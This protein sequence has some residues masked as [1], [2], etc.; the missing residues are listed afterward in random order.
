MAKYIYGIIDSENKKTF[1][2][3][4]VGNGE[5]YIVQFGELGA[6]VSD[7]F[8]NCR[9]GIEEAKTHEKVLCKIMDPYSLI[10]MGFGLVAKNEKEIKNIQ[11]R[12]KMQFKKTLEKVDN[13][14]QIN[15]KI[16]WN[17][18]ILA[19]VLNENKHIKELV[20]A[21]KKNNDQT[22]RV[23][24]GKKV[25]EALDEK[26]LEYITDIEHSLGT[27]LLDS[28]E[29]KNE[30]QDTLT[31]MS[32]LIDKN[33]EQDFNERLNKL[34]EKYA[35]RLEFL[36]VGHLPAYNFTKIC[37]KKM[38]FDELDDA[39]KT[40]GLGQEVSISEINSAYNILVRKYHPDL[41]RNKPSCENKFK[42]IREAQSLLTR[43][44]EHYLCS[45]EESQVKQN[46]LIEERIN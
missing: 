23:E 4:G 2:N 6:V 5:T 27:V 32:F 41:H 17:K 35:G 22:L 25:K 33:R 18:T 8:D 20:E 31:N 39:R 37:V 11:K 9:I 12:G 15:V 1:G 14:L 34:E 30:D 42:K 28:E 7:V 13:K 38:N 16:S 40:L 3:I 36:S 21:S 26:K 45:L 24:L 46:F 44:C 10:P 29:N 43:Y 19:Y